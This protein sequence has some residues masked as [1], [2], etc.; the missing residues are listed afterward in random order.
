MRSSRHLVLTVIAVA[1]VATSAVLSPT[2]RIVYNP[3]ASAPRGFYLA[4]PATQLQRGDLVLV[5]L[6]KTVARLAAERGYL[7]TSVPA[8]KEI[9]ALEGQ[10]VCARNG[11]LYIDGRA[12]AQTLPFDGKQR[13]LRAWKG[14]RVLLEGELFLVNRDAKASFDSRYFGPVDRSFVRARALSLWTW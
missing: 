7:P 4:V 12:T 14:C 5:T 13:A 9:A 1:A 2:I 8:L 3:T 6:P 10:P 11:Y